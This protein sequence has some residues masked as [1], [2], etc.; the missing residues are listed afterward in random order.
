MR[1]KLCRIKFM[2]VYSDAR[3][4]I[5]K[6][7]YQGMQYKKESTLIPFNSS[8]ISFIL[9]SFTFILDFRNTLNFLVINALVRLCTTMTANPANMATPTTEYS[10]TRE[11]IISRGLAQ[12]AETYPLTSSTCSVSTD[13]RLTISPMVACV[14]A[15]LFILS[16]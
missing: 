2:I 13:I 14:R 7:Q 3:T 6:G 16:D 4:Q 11:I 8:V 9:S 10:N 12:M 15:L 5:L 1:I